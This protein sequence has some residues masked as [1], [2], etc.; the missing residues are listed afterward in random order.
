MN[1][2]EVTEAWERE[3]LDPRAARASASRGRALAEPEDELRTAFQRDRDR[4]I[5]S[6]AFRRLKHKT[7]VF[8]APEGDHYRTRLTHTLEVAQVARTAARA[9]RL[10]EDLT[11]AV[12]LAHRHKFLIIEDDPYR[13]LRYSGQDIPALLETEAQM[14]G[15][16]WNAEGR[17]IHLGT[18]SKVMAPGLRI[19]WMIGPTEAIRMM[20][21]AKQGA[22][23]HSSTLTQCIAVELL[24][25]G[26]VDSNLPKL[27]SLYRER[28]DTMVQSL[29]TFVGDCATWTH[30]AGG[31]FIWLT[32]FCGLNTTSLMM[33][34]LKKNVAFVSGDSFFFDGRGT[35]SMRL[36]FSCMPP[37]KI[38]EGVRRLGEVI[39][40]QQQQ[41][42]LVA[43]VG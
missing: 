33:A 15:A 16:N 32:L 42:H 34:A 20:S 36:N 11:E 2:R 37:E 22:D 29:E 5:H 31:L 25:N 41:P 14:L 30:P 35:D 6:K 12:A 8:L 10:N 26:V 4:V 9:L 13:A 3:R 24:A 23:L 38:R 21:L 17:I 1:P 19:G 43:G 27:V 7:Q 18:F 40:E 39:A 28:R